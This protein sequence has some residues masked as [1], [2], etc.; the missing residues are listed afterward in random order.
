ML[1]TH[2]NEL[3]EPVDLCRPDGRRLLPA[4]RGWTRRPLHRPNLRGRRMRTKTWDY[5]AVLRDDVA[6]GLV[7][8]D[9]GYLGLAS[10]WSADLRTG[11]QGGREEAAPLSV[12]VSVPDL[13]GS[14][15]LWVSR[16][17]LQLQMA[18]VDGGT[19]LTGRWL[20]DAG[21]DVELDVVAHRPP[22]HESLGVVIPWSERTFQYT[23]KDQARPVDGHLRRGGEL[24]VF[25]HERPAWATLD[26]GRGRW[27]YR[28]RWNWGGGAGRTASGSV[29]GIQVGGRWTV[30]TGYTEN[31]VTVDGR[32]HKVGRELEWTYD[33]D[34][35][36][37]P[38]TVRDP[39]GAIDLTLTP[40][41]DKHSR[42]D[43]LVLRTE[44]HQV[45][46][47]WRG[48]VAAEDGTEHRVD[49]IVG[50]AEES[51]SRW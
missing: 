8:A 12:G 10:A 1:P 35:P 50:F 13:P 41:L 31:A 37:A 27:P 18:E 32:L 38:W 42:T 14:A 33:W 28:T 45:F 2:E 30:G 43:A 48:T 46:G 39:G 5:W 44:V 19:R 26:V 21:V 17:H 49:G 25:D 3:T 36:M 6:V 51:R 4:A 47:T 7:I 40:R 20:D 16:R 22:G 9:V 15:P 23:V 24:F 34:E 11:R 29:V